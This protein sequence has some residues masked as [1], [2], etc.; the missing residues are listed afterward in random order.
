MSYVV[1]HDKTE[2]S[3]RW[4][5]IWTINAKEGYSCFFGYGI[6][7][8]LSTAFWRIR[9]FSVFAVLLALLFLF[10]L[11]GLGIISINFARR[12]IFFSLLHCRNYRSYKWNLLIKVISTGGHTTEGVLR[13]TPFGN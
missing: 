13:N 7:N 10:L 5:I 4:T 2:V 8:G 3:L 6:V 9:S 11:F 12:F 1:F